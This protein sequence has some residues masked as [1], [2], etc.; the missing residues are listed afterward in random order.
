LT[1]GLF[2]L[3][4]LNETQNGTTLEPL[5]SLVF[6]DSKSQSNSKARSYSLTN[7]HQIV[8]VTEIKDTAKECNGKIVIDN[9]YQSLSLEQCA[10][11][12]LV[13]KHVHGKYGLENVVKGMTQIFEF[14][15]R[16]YTK[17]LQKANPDEEDSHV[18][19]S[20]FISDLTSGDSKP[21]GIK[22]TH[23]SKQATLNYET[24]TLY[25]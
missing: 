2:K 13:F 19:P 9:K 3:Q 1:Y 10:N 4:L 22:V 18:E 12:K 16:A 20:A 23:Y 15:L 8:N 21:F 14:E 25:F 7:I 17:T 24:L 6:I 11:G 5:N